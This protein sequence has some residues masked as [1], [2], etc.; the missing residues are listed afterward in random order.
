MK[1]MLLA[2]ATMLETADEVWAKADMIMKVK[3]PIAEEFPRM[4][5]GQILY[6]P[7]FCSSSGIRS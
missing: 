7:S 4:R 1:L 2:G 5:E 6:L 3:E